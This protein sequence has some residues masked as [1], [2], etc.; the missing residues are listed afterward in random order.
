MGSMPDSDDSPRDGSRV[1]RVGPRF[2]FC[3]ETL[4]EGRILEVWANHHTFVP[5]V[6]EW[7]TAY[8]EQVLGVLRFSVE[9]T[10]I[11][12]EESMLFRWPPTLAEIHLPKQPQIEEQHNRV[13]R[14]YHGRLLR[15][16]ALG[17]LVFLSMWGG[18]IVFSYFS[19]TDGRGAVLIL[20]RKNLPICGATVESRNGTFRTSTDKHGIAQVPESKYV[21]VGPTKAIELRITKEGFDDELTTIDL[22]PNIPV[23]IFLWEVGSSPPHDSPIDL[24]QE[25]THE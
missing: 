25:L 17:S 3:G 18:Y 12:H 21:G 19:K 16:A 13:P 8:I 6:H 7:K 14:R 4:T 1:K 24:H 22:I 2:E 20:S 10:T 15:G 11:E 23:K 5:S 9:G